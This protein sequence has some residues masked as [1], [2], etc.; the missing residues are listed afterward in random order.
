MMIK[1]HLRI[2]LN[3]SAKEQRQNLSNAQTFKDL[4]TKLDITYD[5]MIR[6]TDDNQVHAVQ[7]VFSR[8]LKQGDIY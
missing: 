8:F 7:E 5:R 6:T 2:K 1:C 4:W 3:L